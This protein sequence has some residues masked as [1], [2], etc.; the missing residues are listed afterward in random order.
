MEDAPSKMCH[1]LGQNTSQGAKERGKWETKKEFILSVAGAIIGLGNV[2]RFPYL[3]YKNGG[4]KSCY[5]CL[6]LVMSFK[7]SFVSEL[8]F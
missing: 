4:G 8:C 7:N 2:W 1:N 5:I 6:L 3:C